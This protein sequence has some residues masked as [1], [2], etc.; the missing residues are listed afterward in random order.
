MADSQDMPTERSWIVRTPEDLGR[1]IA[2]VRS[3]RGLTQADLA[4]LLAIDRSYLAGL[5]SAN[6]STLALERA[7]RALRRLGAEVTITA[8][9]DG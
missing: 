9:T 8:R 3:E 4:E 7:L 1:A 2:G 5:E 6:G